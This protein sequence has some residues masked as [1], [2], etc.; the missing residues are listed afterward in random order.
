M[1]PREKQYQLSAAN[2]RRDFIHVSPVVQTRKKSKTIFIWYPSLLLQIYVRT[3][4]GCEL[5]IK[6]K[7]NWSAI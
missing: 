5:F 1:Q 4:I 2:A 3:S 7:T 6:C